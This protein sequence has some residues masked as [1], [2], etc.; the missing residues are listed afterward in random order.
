MFK[1]KSNVDAVRE[2]FMYKHKKSSIHKNILSIKLDNGIVQ[3][4]DFSKHVD[5]WSDPREIEFE[6]ILEPCC[7]HSMSEEPSH[8]CFVT[9][10]SKAQYQNKPGVE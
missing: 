6:E 1:E 2:K 9:V 8:D 7:L 3:D 4:Y 10:L 5:E